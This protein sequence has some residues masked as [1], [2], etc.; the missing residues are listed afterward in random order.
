MQC[1]ATIRALDVI[2]SP[3]KVVDVSSDTKAFESI[4][5]MGYRQ[6]P[7]V[8]VGEQHWSGFRPDMIQKLKIMIAFTQVLSGNTARFESLSLKSVRIESDIESEAPILTCPYILICPTYSDCHGKGAVPKAVIK[9]LNNITNRQNLQG[10]IGAGNRNF[11][12]YFAQ[13]GRIIAEKCNVP[14]LYCIE[15][16]GT[17]RDVAVVRVTG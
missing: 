5:S 11:G 9:M 16:V 13:A 10:V 6:V 8:V 1:D 17:E 7:V 12:P 15:L 3:Y 4:Q 14:L 2:G